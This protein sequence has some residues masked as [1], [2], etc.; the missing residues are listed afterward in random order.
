MFRMSSRIDNTA[1]RY[2]RMNLI[3][4]RYSRDDIAEEQ[5][6]RL[7]DEEDGEEHE[8]STFLWVE[9]IGRCHVGVAEEPEAANG[10]R[11]A[12]SRHTLLLC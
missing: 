1:K 3:R 8:E 12:L 9:G 7:R 10:K 4:G 5:D 11:E 6:H 2:T